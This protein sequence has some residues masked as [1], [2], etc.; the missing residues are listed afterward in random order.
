MSHA[1]FASTILHSLN[2]RARWLLFSVSCPIVH[3]LL[4]A[5]GLARLVGLEGLWGLEGGP[6]APLRQGY[7]CLLG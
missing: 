4:R 3:A 6:R 7:P 5:R 1:T 2:S